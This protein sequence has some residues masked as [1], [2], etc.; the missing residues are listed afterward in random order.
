MKS[1]KVFMKAI[2]VFFGLLSGL[3]AHSQDSLSYYLLLA[4]KNNPVVLQ[5]YYEYEA[6][7]QKVPQVGSLPDPELNLGVFLSPMELVAGNQVA[8]I[9]LMQMFPWFGVL[10][11]AKDEMSLMARAKFEL[12]R[13]AKLQVFFDT[14]K[15]WYELFKLKENIRISRKNI[16]LLNAIERLSLVKF[17]T[18]SNAPA[19]SVSAG[20]AIQAGVSPNS[21]GNSPGMQTM[22]SG[23][24]TATGSISS[25]PSA[26]M[27]GNPMSAS[28]NS[29]G[30]TDVYR[31]QIEIG[32]L[33]NN[34]AL[35]HNQ[36]Q[37]TLARF[38]SFLNRPALAPVYLPD[39][40]IADSADIQPQAVTDSLISDNP[41]LG[42]LQYERQSLDSRKK[43]VTKMGYPM[44]GIGLNYSLINRTEMSSSPMNGKDMIMPMVTVTLP[45]YRKKYKAMQTEADLMKKANE[46]NYTT[47][48]NNLKTE[49]YQAVQ[50][51][52][53]ARR[54]VTL[55]A[56][57]SQ[58]ANQSLAI[59]MISFANSGSGLSDVLRVRQQT[60]DYDYKRIEALSDFKTAVAWLKRLT[61]FQQIQ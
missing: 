36:Q 18:A 3:I 44:V 48:S 10:K 33:E 26:T 16:D 53:D 9:R 38:N 41:M 54:R 29:S 61:A 32:E 43:M 14:Q 39:T 1:E 46:E 22:G 40:L 12:F 52:E 5:K 19:N 34:I 60:L 15:T 30:L 6:A 35:L 4:A 51:Y 45:V 56:D 24:G 37:T 23:S 58:L 59:M 20:P 21:S 25:Q 27:Q 17:K 42:M 57:Q 49:Y 31:I 13:D 2:I 7:L 47:A 11:N 50:L 28:G 55:Y 8:D